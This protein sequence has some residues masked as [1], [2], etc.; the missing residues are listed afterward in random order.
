MSEKINKPGNYDF[1]I[2]QSGL[3]NRIAAVLRGM[4][5]GVP[6]AWASANGFRW[7]DFFSNEPP[8]EL[9]GLRRPTLFQEK[10][11]VADGYWAFPIE[12]VARV[13]KEIKSWRP[14][15]RVREKMLD[16]A[17]GTVGY[18]LRLLAEDRQMVD[19]FL[20][21]EGCF[22][23]CDCDK[24]NRANADRA[25][26]NVDGGMTFDLDR[27]KDHWLY[28]IA[29]WFMLMQCDYL[30]EVVPS[31]FPTAHKISGIPFS[32]VSN[33]EQLNRILTLGTDIEKLKTFSTSLEDKKSTFSWGQ[34]FWGSPEECEARLN[35]LSQH[36]GW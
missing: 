22:L 2:A 23:A 18:K 11:R 20:V 12:D 7:S 36:L 30:V 14:S 16:I 29:D 19:S 21:P 3:G 4:L 13:T 17:P 34:E 15:D 1:H 28:A 6:V 24:T 8:C 10:Y 35:K 33:P 9:I 31:T 27:S 25:L 32:M 26:L 5:D